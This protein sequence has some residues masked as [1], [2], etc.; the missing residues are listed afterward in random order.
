MT[1]DAPPSPVEAKLTQAMK[2]YIEAKLED[3]PSMMAQLAYSFL[4]REIR[5]RRIPGLLLSWRRCRTL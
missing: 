2:A 3:T 1:A 5:N 4:C